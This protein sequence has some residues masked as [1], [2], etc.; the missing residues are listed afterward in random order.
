MTQHASSRCRQHLF[1]LAALLIGLT[2]LVLLELLFAAL[3]WGEPDWQDDPFVGFRGV[4]PLFVLN[5]AADRYEIPPARM[6]YFRPQTFPAR[7]AVDEYRVFCLGGSTVQGSPFSTETAFPRWLEINLQA[8]DSRRTWRVINCGGTSYASYRLIPILQEVLAYGPD[9]IIVC[10]GHNEFLEDRTY[11]RIKQQP[12]ILGH[13]QAWVAQL[14]T[15]CLLRKVYLQLRGASG[16]HRSRGRPMLGAEVDAQLDYRGGLDQYHRDEPWQR[17]VIAHYAYNLERM[18]HLTRQAGVPL[19]FINPVSNLR[20]CPPFKSEHRAGLN[21]QD[22]QRWEQLW[23]QAKAAYATDLR[24]A[25][26]FLEQAAAIDDQHAGLQYQ[27][28]ECYDTLGDLKRAKRHYSLAKDLDI[29]PLRM[30]D[31]MQRVLRD[32]AHR[33]QTPLLDAHGLLA[34][35]CRGGIPDESVL[36][37]HVHPSI[38]GHQLIADAIA[39]WFVSQGIVQA[40]SGYPQRRDAAYE[41]QLTSLGS[42]YFEEGRRRLMH[43]QDWANGR[44][45]LVRP[46]VDSNAGSPKQI[47]ES[48]DRK[49]KG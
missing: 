42:L 31:A 25:T 18:V 20:D 49:M 46:A 27:L 13:A 10:S 19:L 11:R 26:S 22:L 43:V 1:R 32:V 8:A 23:D 16:S 2:P 15:Y 40:D 48:R 12:A 45:T 4:R 17:D 21:S 5:A 6:T 39:E 34:Q 38:R 24:Q 29:C 9:L 33:T 14:R 28:G 44:A 47:E 37:D 35:R 36:M 41:S 3:G 7:K 30:L